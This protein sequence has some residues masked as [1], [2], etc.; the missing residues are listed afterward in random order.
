MV[1]FSGENRPKLAITR[2]ESDLQFC[3]RTRKIPTMS[4]HI[5]Y[6]TSQ[7][8]QR[9]GVTDA[10]IRQICIAEKIGKKFATAWQLSSSDLKRIAKHTRSGKI[11]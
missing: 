1:E 4:K 5:Q 7:A 2:P 9:L 8:A 11:L 10:R 6:T 3:F